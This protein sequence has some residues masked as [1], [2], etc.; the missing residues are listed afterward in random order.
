[1]RSVEAVL[2]EIQGLGPWSLPSAS[3]KNVSNSSSSACHKLI[4]QQA[5]QT[6]WI[7]RGKKKNTAM[8]GIFSKNGRFSISG[9]SL[10]QTFYWVSGI[11]EN[12]V[13]GKIPLCA[14]FSSG[15]RGRPAECYS[16]RNRDAMSNS[17]K[18]K[19]PNPLGEKEGT[20]MPRLRGAGKKG[21]YKP[22]GKGK[23]NT[24]RDKSINKTRNKNTGSTSTNGA[25]GG[26]GRGPKTKGVQHTVLTIIISE[27]IP[28]HD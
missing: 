15:W 8:K 19:K 14:F 7:E 18:N 25:A 24:K 27:I 10:V 16:S 26:E 23:C 28:K 12:L 17:G 20:M 11:L 1:M 13:L 4:P 5:F 2:C 9:C 3:D 6:F 21:E 22:K